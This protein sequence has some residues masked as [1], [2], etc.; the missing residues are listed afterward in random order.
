DVLAPA[1]CA[2]VQAEVAGDLERPGEHVRPAPEGAARAVNA[3]ERLLDDIVDPRRVGGPSPDQTLDAR[4]DRVIEDG[5]GGG[6]PVGLSRHR[7]VGDGVARRRGAAGLRGHE[8]SYA[9]RR[10]TFHRIVASRAD[11]SLPRS[12]E[13]PTGPS[14]TPC[15]TRYERRSRHEDV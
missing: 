2:E 1:L 14:R 10:T 13:A 8:R 12:R 9:G 11:E 15:R 7:V 6:V 4:G 5:K 3:F